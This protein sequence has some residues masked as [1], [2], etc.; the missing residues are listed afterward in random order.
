MHALSTIFLLGLPL[1]GLAVDHR[2]SGLRPRRQK[3]EPNQLPSLNDGR[4]FNLVDM[5][6]GKTFFDGWDFFSHPDPTHGNVL[7]LNERDAFNGGLA[8]VQDDNTTV[9]AV[10]DQTPL[11]VGGN[12][13]SVR[14]QSKKSYNG[15]LFIAD[16][17]AMPHGC[18]VWPAWWTVGPNWPSAGEI[19][20]VEGV[21]NQAT[22]QMT[23][24]TSEGCTLDRQADT[25]PNLRVNV[26]TTGKILSSQCAFINGNN[27]GCAFVDTDTR[28]HGRGFNLIAGGVF[29]HLWQ[30]DSIKIWHFARGEVPEDIDAGNPNPA[31]WPTPAAVFTSASCDIKNR[32][33][34]HSL[35]IDTT[36]CGDF[37]GSQYAQSGCP[38]TCGEAVA[39][40]K[41]FK[42]AKWKINYIAVY[43]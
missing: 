16:F 39:D 43:E 38:G 27:D 2:Y 9:L 8:F 4:T 18:G 7:Y 11:P 29:A 34:D 17:W 41:N 30:D 13:A 42:F 33:H 24:H 25:N 28:S 3:R 31:S 32:F 23:L 1:A 12:R 14:I 5:Y 21:N 6:Q 19:D 35:V 26:A 15:G 40:P 22:N 37:A 10:D 36:I 20:V